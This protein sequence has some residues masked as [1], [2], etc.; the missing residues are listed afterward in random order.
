MSNKTILGIVAAGALLLF[1]GTVASCASYHNTANRLENSVRAQASQ[2]QNAY[3]AFWKTIVEMSQVNDAYKEDFKSVLMGGMEA[4][5]GKSGSQAVMQWIQEQNPALDPTVYTKLQTAIEA[6]RTRFANEQELLLD[7]Q[8]SYR[9]HLGSVSGGIWAGFTGHP[10]EVMGTMA[11]TVDLD[12]D[13]RITVLDYP[14]VT[15]SR[16]ASAFA[17]GQDDAIQLRPSKG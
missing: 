11:P 9:D 14:I 2:N 5:Y 1:G 8:R 7:K 12:G 3:D 4:R 17:T 6:G 10:K 16:T 15:S 13:G